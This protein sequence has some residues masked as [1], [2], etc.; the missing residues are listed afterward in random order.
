MLVQTKEAANLTG[1][2]SWQVQSYA[3]QGFIRSAVRAKGAGTRKAYDVISL[4]KLVL[5]R[6]L[7]DDGFDLRTIRSIFSGLFDIPQLTSRGQANQLGNIR[8]WFRDKV[9]IT[10]RRFNVRKMVRRERFLSIVEDLMI[11]YPGLYMIDLGTIVSQLLDRVVALQF[12]K[13]EKAE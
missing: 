7:T 9:L 3:K 1:L 4:V 13:F 10:A 12:D 2:E 8:M 11:E 5:L 6:Q